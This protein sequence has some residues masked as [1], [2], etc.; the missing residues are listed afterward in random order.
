MKIKWYYQLWKNKE[1]SRRR[2]DR[3]REVFLCQQCDDTV[4]KVAPQALEDQDIDGVQKASED[5]GAQVADGLVRD[6]GE[7]ARAQVVGSLQD[8]HTTCA[9]LL[10]QPVLSLGTPG[11]TLEGAGQE[12]HQDSDDESDV[13]TVTSIG[14]SFVRLRTYIII[15]PQNDKD[16]KKAWL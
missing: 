10:L 3:R 2:K 15:I 13:H 9:E 7:D 11:A 12:D 5:P 14:Q 6:L 4:D 1:N 8:P 16:V